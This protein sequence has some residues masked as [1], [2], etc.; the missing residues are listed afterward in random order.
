MK[1]KIFDSILFVLTVVFSFC[2]WWSVDQAMNDPTASVWLVPISWFSLFS[3]FF[4]L[5]TI[6]TKIPYLSLASLFIFFLAELFFFPFFNAASFLLGLVVI[7]RVKGE[8]AYGNRILLRKII[9]SGSGIFIFS[10]A[11]ALSAHYY[12]ASWKGEMAKPIPEFKM[13]GMTKEITFKIL[14]KIS[15]SFKDIGEENLTVDEFIKKNQ[16]PE[17]PEVETEDLLVALKNE[18]ILEESRKSLSQ[19]SGLALSGEEKMS[20]VISR[21][22]NNKIFSLFPEKGSPGQK[23]SAV[24]LALALGLFFSLLALGTVLV[25]L[26]VV[27]VFMLFLVF[28]KTNLIRISRISSEREIID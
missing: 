12:L 3:V 4:F 16:V 21:I 24:Y 11:L 2:S 5:T 13:E 26:W 19:I 23:F 18:L 10:L 28:R 14:S 25:H 22:I 1:R 17:S 7:F 9:R 6:V 20:E 8:M 15:P 27:L